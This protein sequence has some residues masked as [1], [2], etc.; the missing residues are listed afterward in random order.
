MKRTVEIDYISKDE[1]KDFQFGNIKNDYSATERYFMK[2]EKPILPIIGEF[3]FSRCD[4]QNWEEELQKIKAQ[5][6]S[7]V[8]VYIFWNHH[9]TKCGKFD[10]TGNNDINYFL[11]LCKKCG[12]NVILRIGPWC[13]GEV[14]Y[15]GFPDYLRFVLGKRKSTPL[16]LYF[17]KRYFKVLVEEI[18]EYFDGETVMGIQLENEYTGK[19]KHIKKLREIV[20]EMGYKTSFFTMTMWPTNTP[21]KYFVPMC[22]GYPEAPWTQHKR[23]LKPARRFAIE[24]KR[25]EEE[26]GADLISEHSKEGDF[27]KFPYAGCEVGTGN[28][29][30]QHRRPIISDKDGY[31]V[32]FAKFASGMNLL[33]YYMYHGGRNPNHR[34]LQESRI[35]LYPNNYPIIDY[36]FQAPISKDGDVRKHADRLRL[37]HLFINSWSES[38]A[39]S[40]AFIAKEND[41]PY[42]SVRADENSGYVFVCN[43]ERGAKCNDCSIDFDL[44][45]KGEKIELPQIQVNENEIMFFPIKA[46]YGKENFE[47]ITA[48]PI[49]QT[50]EKDICNV[51]FMKAESMKVVIKQKEKEKIIADKDIVEIGKTKLHFLDQD[52]AL[53]LYN[54]ENKAIIANG[55]VYKKGSEYVQ[56]V[57]EKSV[58]NIAS[59]SE[60]SPVKCK[61]DYYLYSSGKRKFYQ[62]S[63]DTKALDNVK[64][65]QI[66]LD[67]K[68]LNL[69]I[70]HNG[71]IVDDYFNTD[72]VCTFRLMRLKDKLLQNNKLIIKACSSTASGVGNV[73]NE[74]GMKPNE[75]EIKIK[76]VINILEEKVALD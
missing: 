58:A 19:I 16:Y 29:V 73:Y 42:V 13:H 48:Q 9:E 55:A 50:Y 3:H 25:T 56:E 54:L 14:R 51:Y 63:I 59:L 27:S 30:T 39:R 68:G 8:S 26:I 64:D 34:L 66:D 52:Q 41:I 44:T 17:V 33:G 74:I 69:Q 31:G 24:L 38:V 71:N 76:N 28:Q 22:G 46:T 7:G 47:Y 21:S 53:K 62:L 75:V 57:K 11:S 5:G 43:Y 18:K 4:R 36:D 23:P 15:G 61:Y 37:L 20:E 72:G 49:M 67:F 10:F 12:L 45:I 40:Q 65:I 1:K 6:L 70:F 2:K 32:A 60:I 35:T